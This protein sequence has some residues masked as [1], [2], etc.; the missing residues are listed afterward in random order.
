LREVFRQQW[1]SRKK[2]RKVTQYVFPNYTGTNKIGDFR[3]AWKNACEVTGV[4]RMF[5]D[6]RRTASRNLVRAGIPEVVAMSI[7]GHKTRSVFDRYNIVSD[8]DLK[9]AAQQLE[10]YGN[11]SA[12]LTLGTIHKIGEN[13]RDKKRR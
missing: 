13:P 10:E 3:T 12:G 4:K 5:H 8:G 11:F 9:K 2:G 1:E 7:T 6:L